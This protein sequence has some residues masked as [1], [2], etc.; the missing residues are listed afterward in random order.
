MDLNLQIRPAQSL[1][2]IEQ[3]HA[4]EKQCYSA[5]AAGSLNAFLERF[6]RFPNYFL[7]A[8][9]GNNMVGILNGIRITV[10]DIANEELKKVTEV[11]F[12]GLHFCVLTVAVDRQYRRSG[13]GTALMQ[14]LI[15]QAHKDGLQTL[16][17]MCEEHYIPFYEQ[18]GFKYIQPSRSEHAGI[19]WHEMKRSF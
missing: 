16:N 19:A 10:P 8:Y 3:A 12:D 4:L 1:A 15:K 13:I 2:E 9:Q 6:R 14:A 7:L 11:P 17:L 5:K 18:I